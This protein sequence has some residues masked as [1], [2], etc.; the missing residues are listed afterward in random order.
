M[1]VHMS[2]EAADGEPEKK[3]AE[4]APGL[5]GKLGITAKQ[6]KETPTV[7]EALG[8]E[9]NRK[10][11][12]TF[13]FISLLLI[14]AA[15]GIFFAGRKFIPVVFPSISAYDAPIYACLASVVVTQVI[16]FTFYCW[17]WK[18]DVA[19]EAKNK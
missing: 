18:H 5:L 15:F 13:I 17:A 16:I 10:V 8:M 4:L 11:L 3:E 6:A 1:S 9:Q 2:G 12:F 19:E 14:V 7:F